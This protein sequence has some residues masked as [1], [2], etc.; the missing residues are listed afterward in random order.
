MSEKLEVRESSIYG[1]GCFALVA[2]PK[3]KKIAAYAGELIRGHRRIQARVDT[4]EVVKVVWVNDDIAIDGAIGGN[5]TAFI[6]HSCEPNAYMRS[7]PGNK[8]I[9]F[10]L[11]DI[12][13]GEEITIDYRDPEHPEVC[14]CGARKCRSKAKR[15]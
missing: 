2:F 11:R 10:A 12:R 13:K 9:F 5:E 14:R 15:S 7:A 4:Q 6:N 8:V 3:R 1:R